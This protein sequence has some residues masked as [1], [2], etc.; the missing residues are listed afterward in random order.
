MTTRNQ[1]KLGIKTG[2]SLPNRLFANFRTLLFRPKNLPAYWRDTYTWM[3]FTAIIVLSAG[4][5]VYIYRYFE[6]LPEEIVLLLAKS[7]PSEILK[8]KNLIYLLPISTL[9]FG[10]L[11]MMAMEKIYEN[12]RAL[13]RLASVL[14]VLLALLQMI[15]VYK[16]I[17]I[18]I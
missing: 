10:I 1:L 18:Y 16:I 2:S 13:H 11:I 4:S 14:I 3:I 8:D 6:F 7:K 9:G 17:S 12:Y 15:A 5:F